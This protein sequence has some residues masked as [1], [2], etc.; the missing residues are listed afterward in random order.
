MQPRAASTSGSVPVWQPLGPASVLT[1]QF[2]PVT[3]RITS[4]VIDPS[5]STGNRVLVGATGGGVWLSQNAAS[6]NPQSI[7]FA[8]LTD[9]L[10]P[11]VSNSLAA[12]I[13]IGALSVQPGG[14]G[15]ILAG[16]GDPNDALDSYY[17]GG[18]LRSTDNGATWSLIWSTSDLLYD[19]AG[20]GFAGFAW[21]T[22]NPQLV[23]AA[24]SQ[25]YQGV[26]TAAP[27]PNASYAGLYYSTDSGAHWSLATIQDPG[28]VD[29][30][31][32][33][34]VFDQ[35]NGNAATSVVW[36]PIRKLFVAAVR[37]HGYYSSTDGTHWT[38]LAAQPGMGLT[39]QAC[40]TNARQLGSVLC[41]VFRGTLAVNPITGDTFA[42]TVDANNQ[43]QGIWQDPCAISSGVCTNP[44]MAFTAQVSSTPLEVDEPLLGPATIRNGDYNL[45]LAAVPSGQDTLLFAGA[46]DLWKCSLTAGCVWRN[47]TNAATCMS[48]QVAGYQHTLA[49]NPS[50]P[51]ELFLG[52]DSGLW[53]STDAAAESGPACSA[54]DAT[55][56]QNLNGSLGSLSETV[57]LSGII[58][59]PYTMMAGLGVNGTAGV[60]GASGPTAQWPQILSGE[61]GP[62]AIDPSNSANWYVNSGPGVSI[63]LCAQQGSCAPSAFGDTPVVTSD[64]V[65]GD[66]S[67]MFLPA[68]FL[69]DPLDP[70]RLLVATCRLWRGPADGSSW[71]GANAISPFLDGL[72]NTSQCSGNALIRTVAAAALPNGSEILYVGMYGAAEGGAT[73]A[74]HVLSATYNP[75]A[76]TMPSWRDLTFNPVTNDS[77]RMNAYGLD[78]TSIFVDPHDPSGQTLYVTIAGTPS[79][80]VPIRTVYASTDGGAHW[81][82][83]SSN[84]PAAPANSIVVDPQDANIAYAAT[85]VGVY[86][87]RQ[88]ASCGG[89]ECWLPYGAGLPQ[90]PAVAL[91]AAPSG[92]VPSVLVAGTYGRGIWQIPLLTAGE[93]FTTATVDPTSLTFSSQPVGNAGAAQTVTLTNTGG[94]LLSPTTITATGD[95]TETGNCAQSA[96][97]AGASCSIQV[98]FTPT[99]PG[100]RIGLLTISANVPGG[101]V[102]VDLSGT[103]QAA[104]GLNVS[105]TQLSFAVSAAGQASDAQI[106]TIANTGSVSA[107]VLA[108]NV[109]GPFSLGPANCGAS[110]APGGTCTADVVF[111]PAALGKATGALTASSSTYA[112]VS[113]VLNGFAGVSGSAQIAPLA[114]DFSTTA[115][116]SASTPQPVTITNAGAVA[117]TGLDLN[118]SAGFQLSAVSCGATLAAGASCSA[119]VVFAPQTAGPQAGAFTVAANELAA[120]RQAALSGTGFDFTAILSGASSTSV[121]SGQTA[122]FTFIVQP[123][124]GTSATFA[125]QCGSLPAYAACTFNPTN[126]TVAANI[127]GTASLRITTSPSTAA[128]TRGPLGSRALSP[129]LCGLFLIP[130]VFFRRRRGLGLLV[131]LVLV[132]GSVTACTGSGGG[133]G[134]SP[135]GG[136]GTSTTP[137]GTYA[138]PVTISANGLSHTV[139]V[140]VTV[141]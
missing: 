31:G 42:W 58:T 120:S 71:T 32:P 35:P 17:G 33:R 70:S 88:V 77:Y 116:G 92:V 5:D 75:A 129:L 22:I 15:V 105:P 29:V 73:L 46:N 56:F 34:D 14:A 68:P 43:D 138:I 96:L 107:D 60:K 9:N 98:V 4:I 20:E 87:T 100:T 132:F 76:G 122:T 52:N 137:A 38:R 45:A 86:S 82:S 67:T 119:Q 36:N 25:S 16:T 111:V 130:A 108:L 121:A 2:G 93:Q 27:Y 11:L 7:S 13:S 135:A 40:P 127:T 21:S 136:L 83:I 103:G 49:W 50:N 69:V 134:S 44:A 141:D 48:A 99:Q 23:V 39:T 41:P 55:H 10:T 54:S 81:S 51:L 3:G 123:L 95:F 66:G 125:F 30:Q 118:V 12:S 24:V 126:L 59:S 114:L 26:L 74:G 112:P 110:L 19:F 90:A 102:T 106:A 61:G 47:T 94:V 72:S 140:S 133:A 65:G 64:D 57:S 124:A 109:T 63:Y 131:L 89:S 91:Q 85:D 117:L 6:P 28:G 128:N 101:Q 37:Y 115:V 113:V 53:R 78:V 1:P 80:R 84:L 8:P 18:I 139:T 62:V 104:T 79:K 97:N